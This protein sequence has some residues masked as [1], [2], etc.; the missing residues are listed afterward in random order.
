[1]A[2]EVAAVVTETAPAAPVVEQPAA[3]PAVVERPKPTLETTFSGIDWGTVPEE[4]RA[5]LQAEVDRRIDVARKNAA[6]RAKKE[7]EAFYRGRESVRPAGE[8]PPRQEA[9]AGAEDKPPTRDQFAT[10]EEFQEKK[11]EYV[12]E[13]TAKAH[14]E[15]REKEAGE[16]TAAE[17]AQ[18]AQR[19]F[20]T[21]VR[22]K[23]PDIDVRLEAVGDKPMH[24]EMQNA[25]SES[26]FAADIFNEVISKEGELDRLFKLAPLAA[27]KEIG[28]LE[29]RFEAAQKKPDA[30]AAP[31][32]EAKPSN[33]PAPIDPVGGK[34]V[35]GDAEPSHDKPNEWAA[36]R[37]RQVAARRK[38]TPARA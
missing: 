30:E 20:Q 23:F 6:A 11:A 24:K 27:V 35:S 33:A 15:R 34:A 29:A 25:I 19:D 2:E 12:A 28:R 17:K 3:Q 13:K 26:E 9:P 14:V 8:P 5:V 22:T 16:R 21:K 38:G 7:T 18:A 4:T 32:R 37:N 10:W 1:M 36:W 31:R